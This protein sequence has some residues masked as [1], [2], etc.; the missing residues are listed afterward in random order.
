MDK[1]GNEFE[2]QKTDIPCLL[3]KGVEKSFAGLKAVSDINLSVAHGSRYA[4]IGPNG[5]GKTTLL[6]LI[7]GALKPTG[8]QI[9]YYGKEISRLSS[10]HR[11]ALGITRTFQITNLFSDMTVIEN[12]LLACQALEK[13]KFV[14]FR[15]LSS[16]RR[17]T[18][19]AFALLRKFDLHEK[20]DALIKNLSYGDRRQIEVALALAGKPRLLLLDEPGAG[21]SRAESH[22]VT[23][24]LK[25]LGREI[26]MIII[27]HDMDM[28]F[29][30]AENI[31]VLHQGEKLAEG[32]KEEIRENSIVQQTYLGA[33]DADAE[34][35]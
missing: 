22:E 20:K 11:A 34:D 10:Y 4:L 19:E 3:L 5:A 2:G 17:F 33:E 16:Y 9:F 27:E 30:V 25:N 23:R 15:P 31:I 21:L 1:P 7:S 12:V 26:T 24:L 28:A 14:M 32:T 8:G 13:A 18:D 29:D 35:Y 6:N